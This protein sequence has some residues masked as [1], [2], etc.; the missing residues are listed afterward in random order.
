M[1]L[2]ILFLILVGVVFYICYFGDEFLE[3][4]EEVVEEGAYVRRG[5]VLGLE[6]R[7]FYFFSGR[8]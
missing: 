7:G 6:E 2:S 3:S 4:L 1:V 5:G 8:F